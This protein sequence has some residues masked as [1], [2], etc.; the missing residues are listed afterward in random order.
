MAKD[1]GGDAMSTN[2]YFTLIAQSLLV[3]SVGCGPGG[4]ELHAITGKIAVVDT[5]LADIAGSSIEVAD[6]ANENN[7]GFALIEPDGQFSIESL[8]SG[9][10]KQGL[11]EGTYK[12]RIILSD[13]DF[14]SRKKAA[15]AIAKRY[16]NF[17]TSG[18][19]ISVPSSSDVVFL[20][21]K[22]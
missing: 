9:E 4:E 20:I 14:E 19:T 16:Q 10:V 6:T 22:K 8:R 1:K 3:L 13:E 15:V 5:E 11:A 21:T 12:A 7:R 18:L 2:V 17:D